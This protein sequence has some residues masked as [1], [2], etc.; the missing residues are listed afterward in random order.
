MTI[1]RLMGIDPGSRIT[2]YGVI[3]VDGPMIGWNG[4]PRADLFVKDGLHLSEKGYALWN[5]LTRPF[6]D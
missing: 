6:L 3:D 1:I 2:G 5:V 4:K